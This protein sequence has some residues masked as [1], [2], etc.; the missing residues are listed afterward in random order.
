VAAALAILSA[1]PQAGAGQDSPRALPVGS[2]AWTGDL[3]GFGGFSGIELTEDGTG[4][5]ALSDRGYLLRGTGAPRAGARH[6]GIATGPAWELLTSKGRRLHGLDRDSE[7][8]ALA[9][10][11]SLYV[12]FEGNVRI[13]RYTAPGAP[14]ELLPRPPEFGEMQA[15]AALEA[16]AIDAAGTL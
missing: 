10:D 13:A 2:Y 9:P 3:P 5:V 14:A 12:S 7:G 6:T 15:N 1:A 8:L 16:L 4:F 11:G